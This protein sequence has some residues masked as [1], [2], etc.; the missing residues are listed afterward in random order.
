MVVVAIATQNRD[1]VANVRC[2]GQVYVS[3]DLMINS[4]N[5]HS[6]SKRCNNCSGTTFRRFDHEDYT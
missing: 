6:H 1:L 5:E 4:D 2:D 3:S